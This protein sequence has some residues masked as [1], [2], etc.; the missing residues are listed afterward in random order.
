MVYR[1]KFL[2]SDLCEEKQKRYRK[3]KAIE[4]TIKLRK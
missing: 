4:D 3:S 1:R 2:C